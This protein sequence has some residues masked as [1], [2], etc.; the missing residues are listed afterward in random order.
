MKVEGTPRCDEQGLGVSK[1]L[2]ENLGVQSDFGFFWFVG[3]FSLGKTG[4]GGEGGRAN[5]AG[6]SL[7]P[8]LY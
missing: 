6:G 2:E 8:F 7:F 4:G 3:Y 1:Q 5:T